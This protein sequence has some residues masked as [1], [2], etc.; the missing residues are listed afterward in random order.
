MT[1]A[2]GL[3]ELRRRGVVLSRA[4]PRHAHRPRAADRLGARAAAGAAGRARPL[5]R[6]PR[7]RAA[8]RPRPRAR[9]MRGCR[10]A[11]T[12][13][14]R[15]CPRC[16]R[17]RASS[18]TPTASPAEDAVR[19]SAARMDAIERVLG[20]HLRPGDRVAVENP[21]YAALYDLLRAQGLALEPVAVDDRGM[22][23]AALQ[24]RARARRA[25]PPIVTPR[26]QNPTGAAL[27]ARAR[28][29]AR[30]GA[31]RL[32]RHAADRGRSPRSRRRQ[33]LHT[34]SST[35]RRPRRWAATR[36]VAKALGPD[37]RL[38][39][40]AGDAQT[41]ARVAGRQQCGPGWVSHILQTL[42]LEP[43]DAT[44]TSQRARRARERHLRAAARAPARVPRRARASRA[45]RL[46]AERVDPRAGGSRHHRGAAAARLGARA[47]RRPTGS[48]ADRAG[49]RVTTATLTEPE[50]AR[51]ARRS[52]RRAR[53][54][55]SQP[56]RIADHALA[57]PARQPRRRARAQLRLHRPAPRV[58]AGRLR[59]P[60][61]HRRGRRSSTRATARS[62]CASPTAPS[63]ARARST[64]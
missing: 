12:A 49:I 64:T 11:S 18:C 6:Q 2:A 57:C 51:L 58:R 37:L 16:S 50:A 43:L 23:A 32:P 27:D 1:V 29:R 7:S 24:R 48:P 10:R 55:R 56:Q 17:S 53:P 41:I 34:V 22:L 39:V 60:R 36:S 13:S 62:R 30:G 61:A 9:S 45:R 20:A 63:S 52:R 47:R 44:P 46:R 25:S 26:G 38:A 31:R 3:A 59:R 54:E 15:R 8:A 5:P 40:L 21:G 42:V 28:A 35:A 4:A 33:P 19:R 14:A